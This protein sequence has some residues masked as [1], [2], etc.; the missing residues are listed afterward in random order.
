MGIDLLDE[1]KTSYRPG[2]SFRQEV[3]KYIERCHLEDGGYFFARVPPSGGL[4]TYFALRSLS[5]LPVKPDRPQAIARFFLSGIAEGVISGIT[6]IFQAV[7][8]LNEIGWMAEDLRN[9]ARQ[10]IM[11]VQNKAGGFGAYEDVDLAVPSELQ[12]TYRAVRVLKTIGA[13]FDKEK[14]NGFVF[15]FLRPDGGYGARGYSTLASTFYAT[16]I[17]KLLGV[18][19]EKLNGTKDYLRTIEENTEAQFI[20]GLYWSTMGLANLGMKPN[21]PDKVMTFVMMCQRLGGG[22]S[23]AA[24]MGIPTLENTFCAVSILREIGAL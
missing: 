13:D 6:G 7:E 16:E 19:V 24:V 22:F 9:Y 15:S 4:D 11:A 2:Q 14:V 3:A 10:R 8:V 23:R 5:I 21:R 17:Y 12:N 18:D 20:E 1:Y